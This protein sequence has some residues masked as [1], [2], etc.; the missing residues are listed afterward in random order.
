MTDALRMQIEDLER[1]IAEY[2]DLREGRLLSFKADDL[3]SLG[4]LVTR[5]RIARSHT[6]QARR[7]GH[8]PAAGGPLR[9]GRVAEDQPV[10]P[11]RG[12]NALGLD[13]S[14]RARLPASSPV[15]PVGGVG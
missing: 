13:L 6:S 3:D 1:E 10:T 15:R 4:E 11:G 5:A 2:E 12:A 14:V 7:V 8:A 9:A